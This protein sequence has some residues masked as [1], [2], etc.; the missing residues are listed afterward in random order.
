MTV[1]WKSPH[2]T[3]PYGLAIKGVLRFREPDEKLDAFM[4]DEVDWRGLNEAM[5]LHLVETGSALGCVMGCV[6]LTLI[7]KHFHAAF[8]GNPVFDEDA[9]QRRR[10]L[11]PYSD[12]LR[13]FGPEVARREARVPGE[14]IQKEIAEIFAECGYVAEV[15]S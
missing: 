3:G 4:L 2:D 1:F 5:R 8:N 6:Q 14:V 15:R 11:V 9:R 10:D 7:G 12:V 13:E